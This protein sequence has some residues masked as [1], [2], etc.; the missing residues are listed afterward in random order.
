MSDLSGIGTSSLN[1]IQRLSMHYF[2]RCSPRTL[3]PFNRFP[4]LPSSSAIIWHAAPQVCKGNSFRLHFFSPT[5]LLVPLRGKQHFSG[6][7]KDAFADC[8]LTIVLGHGWNN[9]SYKG[10]LQS[11]LCSTAY[12]SKYKSQ[13]WHNKRLWSKNGSAILQLSER[14]IRCHPLTWHPHGIAVEAISWCSD[15]AYQVWSMSLSAF[16]SGVISFW[17]L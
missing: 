11:L 3:W 9:R 7:S 13:P 5:S 8:R 17:S 10:F 16:V 14:N 4:L 6:R 1:G 12:D 15:S 2:R